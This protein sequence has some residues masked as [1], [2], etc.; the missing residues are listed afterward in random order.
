ML[1]QPVQKPLP[2]Q[3]AHLDGL[4]T[5]LVVAELRGFRAAARHLGVTPSAVSQMIGS[6]ERRV[7]TPLISRTTRSLALTEAGERLLAHARPGIEMLTLGL[8]AAGRLG[9]EVSGR[10][11]IN[12]PRSTLPLLANRLLP[13]FC[14]LYPKLQLEIIGEDRL[15]DIV[16]EGF[17]G[18]IR[19]A[20]FVP[21]DMIATRLTPSIRFAVVGTPLFFQRF[22][23]PIQPNDL[24]QFRCIQMRRSAT[25]MFDW[26]FNIE[27]GRRKIQVDG[28]LILNDVH[29]VTRAALRGVGLARVPVPL[30]MSQLVRG[31]LEI[32]LDE[33]AVQE[34]G[35]MFY[36]PNHNHTQAKLRAFA[37]FAYA[38]M[39]QD[40][41]PDDYLPVLY[42]GA[43]VALEVDA[44][45]ERI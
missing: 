5:F 31:E 41:E 8:S 33:F 17:D 14:E 28:P 12:S 44:R 6:L 40:F 16:A 29:M 25:A 13:D 9:E 3:R 42:Q 23:R 18:G 32:V 34:A 15:V 19:R 7:G 37:D 2:I 1:E 24:S 11:R 21:V 27:A 43:G 38:R 10:L 30:I 36:Y 20:D 26:E 39:R 22:G 4:V 45:H 35:L